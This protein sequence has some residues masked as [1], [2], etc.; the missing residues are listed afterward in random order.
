MCTK[1][2]IHCWWPARVDWLFGWSQ[3][4]RFKVDQEIR[5]RCDTW[6]IS[7][8]SVLKRYLSVCCPTNYQRTLFF[9]WL[10][11]PFLVL[12]FIKT[13][14]LHDITTQ[15]HSYSVP[16]ARSKLLCG[17]LAGHRLKCQCYGGSGCWHC[18]C[19]DTTVL[20]KFNLVQFWQCSWHCNGSNV[21]C[22]VLEVA[23]R[24]TGLDLFS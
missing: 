9:H 11:T 13:A 5:S 21:A 3:G 17:P 14:T 4:L 10:S 1:S 12:V 6:S 22:T 15:E 18:T 7:V 19:T 8:A 24:H 23:E 20:L 2:W 16:A